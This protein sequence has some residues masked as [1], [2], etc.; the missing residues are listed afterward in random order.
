MRNRGPIFSVDQEGV[1]FCCFC[2]NGKSSRSVIQP[3][4]LAGAEFDRQRTQTL[5]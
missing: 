2:I 4:H 3:G 1:G 5:F